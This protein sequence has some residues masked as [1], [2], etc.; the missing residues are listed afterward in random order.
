METE[1]GMENE[2]RQ[3]CCGGA[4]KLSGE[5]W[6]GELAAVLERAKDE[7]RE[8]TEIRRRIAS[9]LPEMRALLKRVLM[10]FAP[11]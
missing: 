2:S 8:L 1:T 11:R 9:A 6:R 5:Q 7:G 4:T 10:S 3:D